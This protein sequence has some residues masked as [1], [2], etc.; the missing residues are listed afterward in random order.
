MWWGWIKRGL[1]PAAPAVEGMR[2]FHEDLFVKLA[3]HPRLAICAPRGHGKSTTLSTYA[4]WRL[5]FEPGLEVVVFSSTEILASKLKRKMDQALFEGAPHLMPSRP[6]SENRT[7]L[8]NGSVLESFS[9][10]SATRGLRPDLIIADD[11]VTEETSSSSLAR[12]RQWRWFVADVLGMAH[13][14]VSRTVH[15]ERIDFAPTQ[16]VIAGT[17]LHYSDLLMSLR[18]E[19]M[20]AWVRYAAEFNP[21]ELPDWPSPAVELGGRFVDH[22]LETEKRALV[23]RVHDHH[24][25]AEAKE[26]VLGLAR[27]RPFGPRPGDHDY[28]GPIEGPRSRPRARIGL[29]EGAHL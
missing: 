16:V 28:R 9:A 24:V 5:T 13:G 20:W 3:A 14:G 10:G 17:P 19:Q 26:R 29:V 25:V 22:H 15:G 8:A 12:S 21:D 11:V 1:V 27:E 18:R 2:G 4:S 7:L 6:P 23:E